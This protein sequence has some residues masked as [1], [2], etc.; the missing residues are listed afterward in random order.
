MYFFIDYNI[1]NLDLYRGSYN[2]SSNGNFGDTKLYIKTNYSRWCRWFIWILKFLPIKVHKTHSDTARFI[3][4]FFINNYERGRVGH[5]AVL[6]KKQNKVIG[7]VGFNN[8]SQNATNGEIGICLNPDFW[9][10]NLAYELTEVL[11]QYG[12]NKLNLNY[13]YAIT[14]NDNIYSK[15]YLEKLNFTHNN[16]FVKRFKNSNN[17]TV[18]CNK[19]VL[20]RNDYTK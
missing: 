18:K 6:L 12:F 2:V 4:S 7:N 13:I 1:N 8:I 5:Y 11:L 14:Y 3:K 16:D 10:N 19:F 20:Y 15:R 17:K 9:G